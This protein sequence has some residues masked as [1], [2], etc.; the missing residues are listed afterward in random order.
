MELVK[1]GGLSIHYEIEGPATAPTLLLLH[2]LGADMTMW[3]P[4]LQRWC[5]HFRVIRY[6]VRGH[7]GSS[8]AGVPELTSGMLAEDALAVL[9][10]AHVPRAHWCGISMGGMSAMWVAAHHPLRVAR[11]VLANTSAYVPPR[12]LWQS[13][14]D[15]VRRE[16]IA[17]LVPGIL[18]RWFTPQFRA[19]APEQ[20]EKVRAMLLR[21]DPPSYAAACAA[22]RDMDQRPV[23]PR[24][25]APTLVICADQDPSTPL[26]HS[27]A[28]CAAIPGARFELLHASH[29]SNVEAPDAFES[30]VTRFLAGP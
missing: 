16:G 15:T 2:S 8:P 5:S 13:R 24:I 6:E 11:L 29:L 18:E 12:T 3:E 30:A 17:A 1:P 23:L 28:L 4:Q 9:D 21:V 20:V 26:P 22:I 7:G 10:A 25:R 14:I 19:A 27:E